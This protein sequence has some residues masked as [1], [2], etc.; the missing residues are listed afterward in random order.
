MC[1]KIKTNVYIILL[2]FDA[3]FSASVLKLKNG[4]AQDILT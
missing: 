4:G 2:F 1:V 3:G